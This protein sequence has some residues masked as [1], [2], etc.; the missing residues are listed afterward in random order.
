MDSFEQNELDPVKL[1]KKNY[2]R[3]KYMAK[4][5]GIEFLLTFEEFKELRKIDT[6]QY[7]GEKLVFSDTL[8]RNSWSLDRKDN[9]RGYII[10]NVVVCSHIS[11][12]TKAKY[13]DVKR[14]KESDELGKQIKQ[15]LDTMGETFDHKISGRKV[16]H[17]V[18]YLYPP[19]PERNHSL[20]LAEYHGEGGIKLKDSYYYKG[21]EYIVTTGPILSGC[22]GD[23]GMIDL[24]MW[25]AVKIG[26]ADQRLISDKSINNKVGMIS[27]QELASIFLVVVYFSTL[28]LIGAMSIA[29]VLGIIEITTKQ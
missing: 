8:Q 25:Y 6:C 16:I 22:R 7:T 27:L 3:R 5:K 23:S 20:M 11:N 26:E 9:Q 21:E 14:V 2:N 29:I 1:L 19:N 15:A 13:F 4:L 17:R 10:D 12:I 18:V 28:A 24:Y